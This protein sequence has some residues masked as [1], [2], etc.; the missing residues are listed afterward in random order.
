MGRLGLVD[1]SGWARL[2]APV[3]FLLAVTGIVLVV[4]AG[5]RS[6]DSGARTSTATVQTRPAHAGGQ[7][8]PST[9]KRWYVIRN[10]DTLE[11][12]AGQVG[13]TVAVLLRLNP[14]VEPTALRPGERLRV[15]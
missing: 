7:P 6:D 14:D 1:R 15:R 3:L 10:G 11:A 8:K 4:R 5:L 13:T 12:I 9:A 2:L